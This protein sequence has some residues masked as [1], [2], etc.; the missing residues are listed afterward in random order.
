MNVID[1]DDSP[2]GVNVILIEWACLKVK[3]EWET[4]D[5][6]A[7]IC[8]TAKHADQVIIRAGMHDTT[9]NRQN[10]QVKDPRGWHYTVGYHDKKTLKWTTW[11]RYFIKQSDGSFSVN[12]KRAVSPNPEFWPNNNKGKSSTKTLRLTN[13]SSPTRSGPGSKVESNT[14]NS[15]G[16]RGETI[17]RCERG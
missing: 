16:P 17:S 6:Y 5:K 14:S 1:L 15:N 12:D 2:P 4:I 9:K 8:A 7:S 11:H 13:A 3:E 10:E